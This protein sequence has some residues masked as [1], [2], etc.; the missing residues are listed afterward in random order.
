MIVGKITGKTT[1]TQFSFEVLNDVQNLE[2]VQI[3]HDSYGYVLGQ[4]VELEKDDNGTT[5]TCQVI[6]YR[7][8]GRVNVPRIP[9]DPGTEILYAEDEFVKKTIKLHSKKRGGFLGHL[10]GRDIEMYLDLNKVMTKHMSVLAKSGSG[11]SYTV[12]VLLEEIM[13]KGIPVLV[14]DPHGEYSTLSEPTQDAK[15]IEKLS[16]MGL[17][18]DSYPTRVWGDP[19]VVPGAEPLTIPHD[20]S[21]HETADILP[22]KPN[23]SQLAVLYN[24]FKNMTGK[25][26]E[27]LL[28]TVDLD[29][30]NAKYQLTSML[31]RLK[32]LDI[33]TTQKT[34]FDKFVKPG[35]CNIINF[36]GLEPYVQEVAT[37]KIVKE[38]FEKRKKKEV[39]PFF[40]VMEE[41]HNFCPERTFG[42]KKSSGILRTVASEG[43]KF[44]LGLCVISQRPA[45][46]DKN[47]LSQCS[48]QIIMKI[49]NPNDLRAVS[50]SVENMTSATE[51]E[52]QNLQVGS[53][54]ITGI[55]DMPLLTDVRP[56]K[57]KHGGEAQTIFVTE[58]RPGD[59]DRQK[60][61]LHVIEPSL[62]FEDAQLLSDKD[63]SV[64]IE[65]HPVTMFTCGQEE[66]T[67][68]VSNTDGKII[69]DIDTVTKK[70]IPETKIFTEPYVDVLK[71]VHEDGYI[72]VERKN[73]KVVKQLLEDAYLVVKDDKIVFSSEYIFTDPREHSMKV[74]P[75]YKEV[76][77]NKKYS[78]SAISP[79]KNL[80]PYADIRSAREAYILEYVYS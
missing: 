53:G 20:F 67:V 11:K 63:V 72:S 46:V 2:Y 58:E 10:A 40:L 12:G 21:T 1:P 62:T 8:E 26:L 77:Y 32:E 69:T 56:R 24:S 42:E 41:A 13:E 70:A 39:P 47:V 65:L 9:F 75:M 17:K 38:L 27:S 3:P 43:R 19:D 64:N 37:Y 66:V 22:K 34:K 80:E 76:L 30:S 15:S 16:K 51:E 5:G 45:R 44:G 59:E 68:V 33:F 54:L 18:P 49:T 71:K 36:K 57:T 78:S 50:K 55:H 60:E 29:D 74:T 4:V 25:D 35:V 73:G 14:L 61:L 7:E 31:E 79:R 23:G 52:I 6:G 48:T 28:H